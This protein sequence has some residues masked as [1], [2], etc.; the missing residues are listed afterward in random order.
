[1][2]Q[3]LIENQDIR[4]LLKKESVSKERDKRQKVLKQTWSQLS[5]PFVARF[6]QTPF[7]TT[8]DRAL[9]ICRSFS[10]SSFNCQVNE[11]L[12]FIRNVKRKKNK[13]KQ[14]TVK[15]AAF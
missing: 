3:F 13:N 11:K 9:E 12:I 1:M 7:W 8:L 6:V 14:K 15:R 4:E 2:E 5:S 10:V